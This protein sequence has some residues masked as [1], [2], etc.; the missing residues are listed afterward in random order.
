MTENTVNYDAAEAGKILHKSANWM[1]TQARAGKIPF[2]RLGRGMVWTPQQISEILRAGEQKP[3]PA[4][5]SRPPARRRAADGG[6]A[7]LQ[8]RPQ[9]RSSSHAGAA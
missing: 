8:A 7:A 5:A 1:K 3:R 6:T 2:T 4:L 9:R